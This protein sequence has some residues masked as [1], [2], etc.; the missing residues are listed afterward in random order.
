MALLECIRETARGFRDNLK[1]AG[2]RVDG[3]PV[4]DIVLI[5]HAGCELSD[6]LDVLDD[7][8]ESLDRLLRRHQW[9]PA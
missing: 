1:S 7:I 6:G 9:Y 3:L 8:R 2:Y 4:M 5:P